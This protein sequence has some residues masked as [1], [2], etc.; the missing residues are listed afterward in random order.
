[1]DDG[2]QQLTFP[3][4]WLLVFVLLA[5]IG[6]AAA[7]AGVTLVLDE[8]GGGG[9]QAQDG[10]RERR[11]SVREESAVTDA[12]AFAAPSV[13]T[14]INNQRPRRDSAG[15]IIEGVS[16]G[17]GFIVDN[18]GFII[19]NEHVV[20]DQQSLT[21][22]LADG[23]E[24]PA[25]LVGDDAPFTD[26]AVIRVP[27]GDLKAL[28]FGDSDS[29]TLGQTL[30]AIGSALFEYRN[31]V[32]TGI[33]S[34]LHRRWLREGVYMEDLIQTDAAINNGNSGGPVITTK[35]EVVGMTTNVVRRLGSAENVQ[36]I[37]F[38]I[39]SKTMQPIVQSMI[40]RGQYPR[41]YLGVEHV[42]IDEE[43]AATLNLRVDRGAL[44]QRVI[45]GSPA[46]RAGLRVGDIILRIGRVD[47]T[48]D[49]PFVN[50]LSKAKV[51]ER[52]TIQY[53]RDGRTQDAEVDLTPR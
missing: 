34:G 2:R 4:G 47:L 26:L 49:M 38:A 48:T 42:N 35:G 14:V 24:R 31:S 3:L 13:V 15:N 16:V 1:M 41:P 44:V 17:S 27:P 5:L 23:Q 45:E 39:S 37:A 28:A 9:S 7:G 46:Q 18:R 19:T 43:V 8:D 21:V 52:V 20:H 25:T 53:Y 50:A 6:G 36:G 51:N 29:L 33:V 32:S 10:V 40:E 11:V 22:V 12:I 30:I